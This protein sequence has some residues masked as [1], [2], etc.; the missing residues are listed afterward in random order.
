MNAPIPIKLNMTHRSL[1]TYNITRP[2]PFKWFTPVT[3]VSGLLLSGLLS[4]LN[5]ASNGFDM[6]VST[7][8]DPN[9]TMADVPVL[10][11]LPS[12]LTG[13]FKTKCQPVS[14]TINSRF[15]T[16]HNGL[17]YEI[18]EIGEHRVGNDIPG[19]RKTLPALIYNNNVLENCTIQSIDYQV[20]TQDR[21]A[22]QF[23]L[24]SFGIVV[25]TNVYCNVATPAGEYRYRVCS[26]ICSDC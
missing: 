19:F 11:R 5:Y 13:N 25:R 6:V 20:E 2:Y 22:T 7:T 1:F 10:Q 21:A 3:I 15:F 18:L 9:A 16:S 17:Q 14:L 4:W 26:R 23:I 8:S 12:L 24:S